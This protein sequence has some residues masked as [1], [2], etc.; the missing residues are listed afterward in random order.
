MAADSIPQSRLLEG[1]AFFVVTGNFAMAVSPVGGLALISGGNF[2]NLFAISCLLVVLAF[3]LGFSLRTS[4]IKVSN[5][6]G[7]S[8]G[9][10][11]SLFETKALLSASIVCLTSM[12]YGAGTTFIPVY[13]RGV[14]I[15]NIGTFYTVYAVAQVLV[16]AFTGHVGDK[17]GVGAL[18][19]PGLLGGIAA[20]VILYKAVFLYQFLL[21]AFICGLGF[22]VVYPAL[23]VLALRYV[24]PQRRGAAN[25]T[26]LNGIDLGLAVGTILAGAVA[27]S[28]G[29]K[30]MFLLA[31]VPVA[32]GMLIY[33]LSYKKFE[34]VSKRNSGSD[35]KNVEEKWFNPSA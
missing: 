8:A 25:A 20:M 12:T 7:Q 15:S 30:L 9:L 26:Y 32:I 16:R 4:N 13:A 24:T 1:M 31:I 11:K 33:L 6:E 35:V 5:M 18:I 19:L 29:I 22:G 34:S 27:E 17:K 3:G 2:A 23:Q 28:V 10:L 14:G 21:A